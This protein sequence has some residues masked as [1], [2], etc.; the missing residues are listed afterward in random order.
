MGLNLSLTA[1]NQSQG[2]SNIVLI[3]DTD[4]HG[5]LSLAS[6]WLALRRAGLEPYIAY[7][8]FQLVPRGQ[9]PSEPVTNAQW[10]AD[11]ISQ[12]VMPKQGL[13]LYILDIPVNNQ[14][15][16]KHVDAL[17]QYVAVGG[18]VVVVNKAGHESDIAPKLY[19]QAGVD[20]VPVDTDVAVALYLPRKLGV[21]DSDIYKIAKSCYFLLN[22]VVRGA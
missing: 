10:L 11:S 18:K 14:A 17:R 13:E 7:S 12:I 20:Y 4:M 2:R 9:T 21:V 15:P 8:N 5:G 1:K 6:S 22:V 16:Q 19:L 3:S